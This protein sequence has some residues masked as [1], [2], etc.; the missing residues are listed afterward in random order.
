QRIVT[1]TGPRGDFSFQWGQTSGIFEDASQSGSGSAFG[2][3]P[4]IGGGAS[5]MGVTLA[6][7]LANCELR[8]DQPGY[9]SSH[10]PLL[11]YGQL[12][13]IDVGT[14]IIH[15]LTGEEGTTVSVLSMKAP[16]KAKKDFK[17]G[18]DQFR[19]RKFKD[20]EA[21]FRKA[22]TEYPDYADAWLSLGRTERRLGAYEAAHEDF[23]KAM[24]L[25]KK[26]L[27]PWQELGYLACDQSKW[28]DAA[29]YLDQATRLDP[30][31]S[32]MAW[33]FSAVADF[34]LQ[35]YEAAERSIRA[36]LR[37]DGGGNPRAKYLLGLIL[38]ARNDL[39]GGAEALR[40]FLK[41]AP[42]GADAEMAKKQLLRV[43]SMAG[44]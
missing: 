21:S 24:A 19:D 41:V 16:K 40:A 11:N 13:R 15:R 42:A 22:V 2:A 1:H 12:D 36:E 32:A 4:G 23:Q 34:N 39:N 7:P 37:L 38:L 8:V 44:K 10:A 14:L 3:N 5:G 18:T 28:E 27:G 25:D 33:F 31:D 30:M 17:K 43:E 35:R 26:L 20:A 9:T 29:K 6:N